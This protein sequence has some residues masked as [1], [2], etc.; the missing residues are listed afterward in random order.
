MTAAIALGVVVSLAAVSNGTLKN[1][2]A[3]A[4]CCQGE[5]TVPKEKYWSLASGSMRL[6]HS[7]DS[8]PH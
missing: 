6:E 2:T 7:R 5:C 4:T 1:S 3:T 8:A